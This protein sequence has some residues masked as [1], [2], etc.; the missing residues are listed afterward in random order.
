MDEAR[1]SA[2]AQNN[3]WEII[4]K[5]FYCAKFSIARQCVGV[6]AISEA[7]KKILFIT[8]IWGHGVTAASRRKS[9]NCVR[10]GREG[11]S[12]G[13]NAAGIKEASKLRR[14]LLLLVAN[15]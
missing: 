4:K 15:K 5:P 1:A 10:S 6:R 12:G 11:V 7:L 2:E 14:R 8:C 3:H 13:A 9:D